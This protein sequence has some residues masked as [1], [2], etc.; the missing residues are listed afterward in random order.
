MKIKETI[1]HDY[2]LI[3]EMNSNIST[4]SKILT[5]VICQWD[6]F[7]KVIGITKPLIHLLAL[8]AFRKVCQVKRWQLS[9]LTGAQIQRRKLSGEHNT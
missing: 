8:T 6:D 5:N 2:L 1:Y 9:V 7:W 3:K 4:K